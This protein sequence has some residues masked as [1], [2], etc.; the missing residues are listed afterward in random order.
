MSLIAQCKENYSLQR[1]VNVGFW[2]YHLLSCNKRHKN[3]QNVL[4]VENNRFVNP[5]FDPF[6]CN[7][8]FKIRSKA[9]VQ[10]LYALWPPH[11][12]WVPYGKHQV[13]FIVI[14]SCIANYWQRVL[15]FEDELFVGWW[16]DNVLAS[17]NDSLAT[18]DVLSFDSLFCWK[19]YW[20]V[21]RYEFFP[22]FCNLKKF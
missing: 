6:T 10:V 1:G 16:T 13:F 14:F 11:S 5:R 9:K 21:W 12:L 2:F 7:F 19:R 20:E 17:G 18:C 15:V 3:Q 22:L 8:E 4:F